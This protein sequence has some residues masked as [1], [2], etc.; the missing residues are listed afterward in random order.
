VTTCKVATNFDK[1]LIAFLPKLT[2]N[3]TIL[4]GGDSLVR[5]RGLGEFVVVQE[6]EGHKDSD[7]RRGPADD[8]D[9]NK[10]HDQEAVDRGIEVHT[11]RGTVTRRLEWWKS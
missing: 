11:E 8:D 7:K 6:F 5:S 2:P 4:E 1:T 10:S 9:G 3:Q